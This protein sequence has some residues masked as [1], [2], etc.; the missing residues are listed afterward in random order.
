MARQPP[1]G[2][3]TYE[4]FLELPD[5][6]VGEIV[7]GELHVSPRPGSLQA[8]T[9]IVLCAELFVPFCRGKGGPG[10]WT[11]LPEPEIRIAEQIVVP[12]LAGWRTERMPTLPETFI[13]LAPDWICEVLSE[14]TAAFDRAKKMPV[15]ARAGVKHAWLIDPVVKTLEVFRL[16]GSGW[17]L[18]ATLTDERVRAEPFD[19]IEL[20]LAALWSR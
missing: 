4:A 13:E 18:V 2:K 17:H 11:I 12:D 19:A 16:E 14:G 7:E 5:H 6:V 10:G 15:Y 3:T 20:D 9:K 1:G 8:R